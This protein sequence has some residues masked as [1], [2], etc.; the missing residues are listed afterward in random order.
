MPEAVLVWFRNDL[1]LTDHAAL[2]AA[3]T[4]DRAVLPVFVLDEGAVGDW[5]AGGASRWWLHHS[6]ASLDADLRAIGSRLVLR[7]GDTVEALLGLAGEIGARSIHFS[8]AYE[9]DAVRLEQRLAEACR[10]AG[11]EPRRFRGALLVEPDA[12]ETQKGEPFR[13]FT[14]FWRALRAVYR[15][16]PP[17]PSPTHL[18]GPER[19]PASDALD[20]W[21]LL[22]H[23]PDWAGGLR[24]TWTPGEAGAARRLAMLLDGPLARYA[25]D[26]DRPDRS[27]TSMLSPHVHFGEI[28]PAQCWR[29]LEAACVRDP[30]LAPGADVFL[31]EIA[32]REFSYHLLHHWPSLPDAPFRPEFAAFAWEPDAN[33]ARAGLAAWSRGRTGYPI[34]DAGMRQLWHTGWMHNRVRMVT[35][36]FLTKHLLLPWREGA[37]WFWDTLVDADLASNS[38]GWQ[39]VAGSGADAAPYFRIFNPVLQGEKFDPDGAYIRRWVPELARLSTEH[40]H[41]PWRAPAPALAAAGVTL[42]KT[43][44]HPIVDHAAARAR[45]LAAYAAISSARREPEG[46]GA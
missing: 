21:R 35:A 43:Y 34:V 22:P 18:P 9:P 19:W 16:A 41:A 29:A 23:A 14:P 30:A 1:R 24:A 38:A 37:R 11:I 15:P 8:R 36:S 39:W 33:A 5:R 45:A 10:G 12:L 6:L 26:R 32:W 27:G 46:S 42:G 4:A 13:V 2:A 17:R 28:S 7:R 3:A 31:K 25:T 44:P 40:L 20:A